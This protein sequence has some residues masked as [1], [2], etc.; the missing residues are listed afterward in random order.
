MCVCDVF[1]SS[2]RH[3]N[4]N[5]VLLTLTLSRASVRRVLSQY[6]FSV[7]S[8]LM[9][10]VISVCRDYVCACVR[11]K[12]RESVW[13]NRS[14]IAAANITSCLRRAAR[15][16]ETYFPFISSNSKPNR[17]VDR[18]YAVYRRPNMLVDCSRVFRENSK[19]KNDKI[20][21]CAPCVGN[22]V[23]SRRHF[24]I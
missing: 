7:L 19:D 24:L 13:E 14:A 8:A 16:T 1:I 11:E 21:F 9:A 3:R 23:I 5:I 12:E 2:G 6:D 20:L 17:S 4:V 22:R 15:P 18:Q 10:Y